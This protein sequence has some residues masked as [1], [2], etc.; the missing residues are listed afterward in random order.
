MGGVERLKR[1]L[2]DWFTF[3]HH[4][5]SF[6]NSC[7]DNSAPPTRNSKAFYTLNYISI[8]KFTFH[9]LYSLS[10]IS[11]DRMF[12]INDRPWVSLKYE[13]RFGAVPEVVKELLKW[14]FIYNLGKLVDL[15]ESVINLLLVLS[16]I[17]FLWFFKGIEIMRELQPAEPRA[18]TLPQ[19]LI[20]LTRTI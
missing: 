16:N 11:A 13:D 12:C 5:K 1:N 9:N 20:E 2:H 14:N 18:K 4:L 10:Y 19:F 15:F 8:L 17:D 6:T 3:L 7:I